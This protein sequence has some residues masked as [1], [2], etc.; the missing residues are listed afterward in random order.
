VFICYSGPRAGLA[1][2]SVC[3]YLLQWSTGGACITE[4]V[5]LFVTV[6]HGRGLHH[7]VIPS[8]RDTPSNVTYNKGDTAILQCSVAN[9]GTKE[10]G[11][12]RYSRN[13]V[14]VVMDTTWELRS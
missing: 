1:S 11:V 6:V 8:F 3:V 9:L 14:I 2:L 4:C 12:A 7:Y 13:V 10:V 5:C